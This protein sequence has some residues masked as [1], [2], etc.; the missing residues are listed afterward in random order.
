M[1]WV[2]LVKKELNLPEESLLQEEKKKK[3][4]TD[5]SRQRHAL[6]KLKANKIISLSIVIKS[7]EH[8]LR[9][10][11]HALALSCAT[12]FAALRSSPPYA[13]TYSSAFLAKLYVD[14]KR[15][16]QCNANMW[17]IIDFWQFAKKIY[18]SAH[19]KRLCPLCITLFNAAA[20][21]FVYFHH[22][23]KLNEAGAWREMLEMGNGQRQQQLHRKNYFLGICICWK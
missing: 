6:N 7:F 12:C 8:L 5:A 4:Q 15:C 22:R 3:K 21:V 17:Q 23:S 11:S 9:S 13:H 10:L 19:F 14:A 16:T 1:A 20:I 2:S 18:G